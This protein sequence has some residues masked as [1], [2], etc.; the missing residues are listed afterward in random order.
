M[1]NQLPPIEIEK[2]LWAENKLIVAGIDEAGRGALAGPIVAA[3]VIL[4]YNTA[5]D[6]ILFGVKDSKKMTAKQRDEWVE[7]IKDHAL[8]WA[9]GIVSPEM[10]DEIGIQPANQLAMTHAIEAYSNTI[11]H[12]LFDFIHWKNCPFEGQ[13]IKKG[14]SASLSIA[15]ASIIAKTTRDAIMTD[16]SAEFPEYGWDK[17]KGYGTRT[18]VEAIRS[19]GYTTYHRRSFTLK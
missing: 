18:H 8:F 1:T 19:V 4:P 9:T 10:I 16:L 15:A 7:K 13:R 2:S 5:S 3:M 14:E 6:Q 12:H 17:N 11:D